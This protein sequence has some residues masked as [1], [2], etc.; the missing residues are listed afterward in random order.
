MARRSN[1]GWKRHLVP[2]ATPSIRNR[3]PPVRSS[4][5]ADRCAQL[6]KQYDG[7]VIRDV[8]PKIFSRD[9]WGYTLTMIEPTFGQC[10]TFPHD[11]LSLLTSPSHPTRVSA[12]FMLVESIRSQVKL[13]DHRLQNLNFHCRMDDID[14][15]DITLDVDY[16]RRW[17]DL[18]SYIGVPEVISPRS[19][20]NEDSRDVACKRS[21]VSKHPIDTRRIIGDEVT[22]AHFISK[23]LCS[24][25]RVFVSAIH[26]DGFYVWFVYGDHEGL[27]TTQQFHI[28]EEPVLLVLAVAG[29]CSAH[30]SALGFIPFQHFPENQLH[31]GFNGTRIRFTPDGKDADGKDFEAASFIVDITKSRKVCTSHKAVGRGTTCIPGRLE[32]RKDGASRLTVAS[33]GPVMLKMGFWR[34][35]AVYEGHRIRI[36]RTKLQKRK[37]EALKYI[38]NLHGSVAATLS[39]LNSPRVF[40]GRV[41]NTEPRMFHALALS[42]YQPLVKIQAASDFTTVITHALYGH[43]WMWQFAAYLHGDVSFNNV[44]WHREPDGTIIGVIVDFDLAQGRQTIEH[45]IHREHDNIKSREF[46]GRLR[47]KG[48]RYS[49]TVPCIA[50]ESLSRIYGPAKCYRQDLESFFWLILIHCICH[51]ILFS[52]YRTARLPNFFARDVQHVGRAKADFLLESNDDVLRSSYLKNVD[53]SYKEVIEKWILPVREFFHYSALHFR[54]TDAPKME[55][56]IHD[57][58]QGDAI[59]AEFMEAIGEV[60]ICDCPPCLVSIVSSEGSHQSTHTEDI[61]V[62]SS[63]TDDVDGEDVAEEDSED[64]DEYESAEDSSL[65]DMHL[66]AVGTSNAMSTD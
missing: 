11:A 8:D 60:N 32:E 29:L 20:E 37:P 66:K 5:N 43:H 57:L 23:I 54:R 65:Y 7:H 59:F 64:T 30:S 49:G 44:M 31:G 33:V 63:G 58:P 48:Y 2:P 42:E 40:L 55:H 19:Y 17:Y 6:V 47:L 34:E 25:P 4:I 3:N 15:P 62:T 56:I 53:P 22:S 38:V 26:F 16:N 50:T 9:V 1:H 14:R 28:L 46:G 45:E 10:I 41:E 51:D 27:V 61:G 52:I 39:Q 36:V 13:A 18:A 24:S 12:V 35:Y 21:N